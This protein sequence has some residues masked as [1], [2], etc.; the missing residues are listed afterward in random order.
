MQP[1]FKSVAK[2]GGWKVEAA[3]KF[4]RFTAME[5]QRRV[6]GDEER[7]SQRLPFPLVSSAKLKRT[8]AA[9]R[10]FS[11][12]FFFFEKLDRFSTS[13]NDE[14]WQPAVAVRA[15][16]EWKR[17][18]WSQRSLRSQEGCSFRSRPIIKMHSA[19]L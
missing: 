1:A 14:K 7:G 6:P 10:C 15:K 8:S 2:K 18:R 9:S 5:E 13:I 3:E 16:R 12:F 4:I 17:L 11:F 19:E